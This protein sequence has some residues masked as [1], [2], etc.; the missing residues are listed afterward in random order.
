MNTTRGTISSFFLLCLPQAM[1]APTLHAQ[2]AVTATEAAT[3]AAIAAGALAKDNSALTPNNPDDA[4]EGSGKPVTILAGSDLRVALEEGS[5]LKKVGQPVVATLTAP[6]YVGETLAAPRGT[7]AEGHV[8]RITSG[9]RSEHVSRLLRG[10]LT[11]PKVGEVTIDAL[12]LKDGTRFSVSTLSSTGFT[13]VHEVKFT[14]KSQKPSFKA[15]AKDAFK[16][17][18]APH[19]LQR[20]SQAAFSALPLHPNYLDQGTVYDA[21]LLQDLTL[22]EPIGTSASTSNALASDAGLLRLK[23]VCNLSSNKTELTARVYAEVTE[24]FYDTNNQL[25]YPVGSRLEGHVTTVEASR[26]MHKNGKLTFDFSTITTP[27]S[28]AR[29]LHATLN[30]LEVAG[31]QD[32]VVSGEGGLRAHTS[33]FAQG[34]ALAAFASPALAQADPSLNKTAFDRGGLGLDGFGVLG[35]GAAQASANSALGFGYFGAAKTFYGTFIA[36]GNNVI[37]PANTPIA[38]QVD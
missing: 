26:W 22:P 34:M 36:K 28:P 3:S 21:V 31:N 27:G 23:L 18:E 17:F 24:P 20:L 2:S 6:L 4:S 7:R 9:A 19:K 15:Q 38:L 11:R 35:A 32:I 33:R 12:V 30:R 16:P 37:I 14:P 29:P 1:T 10:D 25:I 13:G 5:R 8:T